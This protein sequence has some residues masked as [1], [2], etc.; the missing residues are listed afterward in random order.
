MTDFLKRTPVI[1]TLFVLMIV[2]GAGFGVFSKAV[3][4]TF[5]DM[6]A[7]AVQAREI[8][9]GM[10]AEQRDVHFW[11]T[12]LLD[13]AYPLAYGGFLAGMALRF[14]GSFGKAAAVPA[15]ATIIVDLTENT[16]QALA[17]KGSADVLDAKEWLTPLKFGLFFLAA[18]IALVAL[19]IAI[20]NLF[21]RKQA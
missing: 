12:V 11:V 8:L 6:T 17:L 9:A 10:T 20:V 2:I 13:T 14:F 1:W 18:A 16:V 4:G 19:I 21:R 7:S 3:G 15:F 5:L